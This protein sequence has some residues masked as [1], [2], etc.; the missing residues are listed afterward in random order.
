MRKT[1]VIPS[2]VTLVGDIEPRDGFSRAKHFFG[3]IEGRDLPVRAPV[4]PLPPGDWA[5]G[6]TLRAG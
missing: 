3:G 2:G 4:A 1:S 5:A 6:L